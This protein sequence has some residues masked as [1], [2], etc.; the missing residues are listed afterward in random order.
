MDVNKEFEKLK[1]WKL[2]D[3]SIEKK[4]KF[5]DFT[6]TI[7]FMVKVAFEAEKINHHPEWSNSYNKLHIK[8][9]THDKGGLTQLDFKLA[10]AIDLLLKPSAV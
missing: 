10:A 1:G 9:T 6:S 7:A 3:D 2:N 4:L 8:L 5:K